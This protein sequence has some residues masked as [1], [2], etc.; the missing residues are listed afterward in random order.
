MTQ[1]TAATSAVADEKQDPI[2]MVLL[3]PPGAGISHSVMHPM[4]YYV[5]TLM[6][7]LI[8]L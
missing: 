2:R 1:E 6:T 4:V 5:C 3:G 7:S 8:L